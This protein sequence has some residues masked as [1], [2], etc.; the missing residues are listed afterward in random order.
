MR[1]AA[2]A[3]EVVEAGIGLQRTHGPWPAAISCGLAGGL[4]RELETGTVVIPPYVGSSDGAVRTCDVELA[5]KLRIAAESLGIVCRSLPIVTLPVLAQGADRVL[6][7]RRGYAA[8][9]MESAAIETERLACIRVV[10]DTPKREISPAWLHPWRAMAD[11][12]AWMD[13][14]FLVREGPRC[15]GLAARVVALAFQK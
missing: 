3:L 2:P 7:A 14:P 10:L 13:L 9:D 4:A 1:K 15:A 11:P 8:A 12:R 5:G 6:W